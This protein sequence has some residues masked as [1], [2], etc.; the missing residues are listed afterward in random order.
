M[1][2]ALYISVCNLNE[3]KGIYEVLL[4]INVAANKKSSNEIWE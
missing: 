1:N 3:K 2:F 4:E